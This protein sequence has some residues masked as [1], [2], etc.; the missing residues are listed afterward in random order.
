MDPLEAHGWRE[1]PASLAGD[2]VW[3]WEGMGFRTESPRLGGGNVTGL[4]LVFLEK[5]GV[6]AN[7]V[8]AFF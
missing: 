7:T 1:Q 6:S 8:K 3:K 5:L 4:A 2:P